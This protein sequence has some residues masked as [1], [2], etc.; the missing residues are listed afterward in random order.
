MEENRNED[1]L[2][3][4]MHFPTFI[5]EVANNNSEMAGLKIGFQLM[6]NL[7]GQVA[8]RASE[9]NDP[10]LNAMMCKMALY[11]I[12]DPYSKEYD[13]ERVKK[14]LKQAKGGTEG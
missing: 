13:P 3:W 1:D 14:I 12:A 5:A 2:E 9:L 10:Q 6:Q 4:K 7:L 8:Q 11:E